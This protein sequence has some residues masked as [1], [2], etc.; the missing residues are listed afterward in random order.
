MPNHAKGA[1]CQ[2]QSRQRRLHRLNDFM[3]FGLRPNPHR[4]TPQVDWRTGYYQFH[5]P[6]GRI[7]GPHSLP[8]QQ[9]QALFDSLFKVFFIFLSRYLFAIGL[10]PIFR[11]GRNLPPN[12]SCIPKQPDSPIVKAPWAET[13]YVV[14][15]LI[16]LKK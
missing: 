4:S 8:F 6:P 3:G 5:I 14:F 13:Y 1:R 10:S 16:E 12:W 15:L 2:P 9:F 7:A 11:L